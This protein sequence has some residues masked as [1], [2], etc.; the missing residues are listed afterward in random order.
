[1]PLE[2]AIQTKKRGMFKDEMNRLGNDKIR[3]SRRIPKYK[4]K[5]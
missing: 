1:M 4:H 5:N 2:L 3:K